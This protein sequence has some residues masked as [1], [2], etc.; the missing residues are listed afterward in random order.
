[1]TVLLE[2]I[3]INLALRFVYTL[4]LVLKS[5]GEHT[6]SVLSRNAVLW[7]VVPLCVCMCILIY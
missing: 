5:S 1:M 2:Y 4:S 6:Y 3:A 7:S